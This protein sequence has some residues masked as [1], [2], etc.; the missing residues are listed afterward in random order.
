MHAVVPFVHRI[1]LPLIR[2][3]WGRRGVGLQRAERGE[4][5]AAC[6]SEYFGFV[7]WIYG[8]VLAGLIENPSF[9][10]LNPGKSTE[11]QLYRSA[12]EEAPEFRQKVRKLAPPFHEPLKSRS[13]SQQVGG[14][15][16]RPNL[17][18][19]AQSFL[20]HAQC[21]IDSSEA[22][23]DIPAHSGGVRRQQSP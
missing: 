11:L 10:W 8:L 23:L 13:Q 18:H 19:C 16:G 3:R 5:E 17:I 20:R 9:A 6:D 14:R 1:A 21:C 2:G 22:R 7:H 12:T 4:S 15:Y